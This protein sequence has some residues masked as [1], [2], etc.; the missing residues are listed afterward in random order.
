MAHRQL[1]H[2]PLRHTIDD[3][4]LC[5]QIDDNHRQQ[6]EQVGCK[7]KV[8]LGIKLPLEYI[9]HQRQRVL[10]WITDNNEWQQEVVL[11]RQ[12][13]QNTNRGTD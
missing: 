2:R 6:R 3:P 1:F 12:A 13:S 10:S 8:K 9:L 5:E 11:C 4:L 7:R